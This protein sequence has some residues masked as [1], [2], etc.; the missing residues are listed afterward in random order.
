[1]EE[2]LL[3][4]DEAAERL[5]ITRR[6]VRDWLWLGKLRGVKAGRSWRIPE[7]AIEEFLQTPTPYQPPV[8]DPLAAV[9]AY[10]ADEGACTQF[11]EKDIL[12]REA[13]GQPF[14][15]PTPIEDGSE[16]PRRCE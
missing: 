1:M 16:Q 12:T 7:S 14:Y 2:R 6:T 10:I 11:G 15:P 4:V 13:E 5:R 9:N 8:I 3:T